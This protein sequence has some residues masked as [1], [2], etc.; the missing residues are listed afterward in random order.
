MQ[1]QG[2]SWKK[3]GYNV[4]LN[5][6]LNHPPPCPLAQL[7]VLFC[8]PLQLVDNLHISFPHC[9]LLCHQKLLL[10]NSDS[11][12][13]ENHRG[14]HSTVGE[15]PAESTGPERKLIIQHETSESM[16]CS[17]K[18]REDVRSATHVHYRKVS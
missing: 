5:N 15:D 14:C 6:E 11:I 9:A 7:T 2:R 3:E 17:H 18:N 8:F 4:K 16:C 13:Q 12:S 1:S 10:C